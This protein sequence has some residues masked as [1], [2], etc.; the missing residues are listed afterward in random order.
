MSLRILNL[1]CALVIFF[2]WAPSVG[3][4]QQTQPQVPQTATIIGTVLDVT[5]GTVP[6]AIVVLQGAS[7]HRTIHTSEDGFFKF[8]GVQPG[9]PL[10]VEVS[11]IELKSWTS[12]EIIAQAGQFVVLTEITL[13]MAPVETSVTA[14]TPEEVAT[15][16]VKMQEKQRVL[17]VVPNFYVTYERAPAPLSPKL[18]FQLAMKTLTDP[19]TLTSFGVTA[20]V[21]QAAGYPSWGLGGED[22]GKRLGAI[23]AGGYTKI[24]IGDAVLPSLL[25]QDPRYFYQGTGTTK[26][27]LQHALET[28]F[29]TRGDNG[30]REINFSN[31][32]G[33]LASGAI[34]NAYY[35]SQ[36]RG[37]GLVARS[38]LVGIASRMALGVVQEFVLHKWTSRPSDQP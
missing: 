12:K 6:S 27:R 14:V 33:D 24:L 25:H 3:V 19:V 15:E 18:K 38:V 32:L 26:S 28:P 1:A 23:S 10:R 11:A 4:A 34:A 29:I 31:I 16:Q 2:L 17:G 30:R 5:G 8:D 37:A 21:Y 22:Y 7:E 20:G 9:V 13:A 35:P 36:D